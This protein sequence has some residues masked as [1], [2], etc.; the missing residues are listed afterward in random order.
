MYG[1]LA[2]FH[3]LCLNKLNVY[4]S[5]NENKCLVTSS[6]ENKML[7]EINTYK[8]IDSMSICL[9]LLPSKFQFKKNHSDYY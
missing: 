6:K 3:C 8:Y 9:Q 4:I 5:K 7:N 1:D 2:N